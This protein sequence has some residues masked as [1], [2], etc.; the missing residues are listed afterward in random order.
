MDIYIYYL[1]LK[2]GSEERKIDFYG[3]KISKAFPIMI[4]II[5]FQ[6]FRLNRIV[7]EA[8]AFVYFILRKSDRSF[9]PPNAIILPIITGATPHR[10]LLPVEKDRIHRT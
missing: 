9:L 10:P 4:L 3:K 8:T 5:R 1:L 6:T 7:F 2:Y